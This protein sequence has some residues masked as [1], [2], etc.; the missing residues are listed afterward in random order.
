MTRLG[1]GCVGLGG[2]A[3]RSVSDDVRLVQ[4]AIDLGVT[5][6]DTADVYG[7][8]A[9]EHVLGRAIRRR[10]DEVTIATKG[11]FVFRDRRPVEQWARRRA[12]ALRERLRS[13][14]PAAPSGTSSAS[15]AYAH[16]DFSPQYLRR[17]VHASLR[18]LRTDRIDLYQLHG[19]TTVYPDLLDQLADLVTVGDVVRFGVGADSVADADGWIGIDG[20]SVVQVPFGV[21]DPHAGATTLPLARRRECE[22]WARGVLG[23]GLLGLAD[24]DPASIRDHP[25]W[26]KVEALRRVA[27]SA[28][29]DQY[30]LAFGFL[31]AF[32]DDLSTILVGSTSRTHLMRNVESLA[33]PPL[34]DDVMRALSELG[35]STVDS[36]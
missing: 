20:V 4:E 7:G 19:P 27:A 35:A 26:S 1:L 6:F 22:V 24:R 14:A 29:L 12:K 3:D 2:G 30:Q 25:K 32:A 11:G 28:D 21:L 5:V 23:G 16:Q 15:N 31:R 36:P 34:S 8:G 33:A 17:A 10:R 18:R 9:S 13:N